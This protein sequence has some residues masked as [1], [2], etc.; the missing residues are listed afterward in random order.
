MQDMLMKSLSWSVGFLA[1][2]IL[3]VMLTACATTR[4]PVGH[5]CA[6]SRIAYP[7]GVGV[8]APEQDAGRNFQQ[9]LARSLREQDAGL[10]TRQDP[11]Q[12]LVL[13]GGGQWGAFGA[14]FLQ[15]WTDSGDRPEFDVV[16][17]VST[18]A[19]IAPY[20]FLGKSYDDALAN[21]YRIESQKDFVSRRGLF[22]LLDANSVYDTGA[23]ARRVLGE[24]KRHRMIELLAREQQT[25][26][27]LLV[28]VVDAD[29]G[30]F[31]AIDLTALAAKDAL[32]LSDREQCMADYMLASGSVP[33]AFSPTF[34]EGRMLMDGS[35]RTNVFVAD[36]STVVA[37]YGIRAVNI[38]VIKNGALKLR[39]DVVRNRIQAIAMRS[40]EVIL[41][42][43]GDTALRDI[44]LQPQLRGQTR[45]VTADSVTCNANDP[46]VV[47][48]LFVPQF[49]SCLLAEGRRIGSQ[50]ESRWTKSLLFPTSTGSPQPEF[51]Q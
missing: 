45:F 14:G 11:W 34:V 25:G 1:L 42:Q 41:D 50:G 51:K 29:N 10:P 5:S 27:R 6:F 17:G 28:G 24:I 38:Y 12:W 31:Y 7:I 26:R 2:L 40:I 19:M 35:A 22:S 30:V 15:G 43:L 3:S 49:M 48:K 36:L 47:A 33:V 20:A 8:D 9:F 13:S 46:E 16:T 4:R 39:P 23:L 32:P 37:R 44:V 21:I 18:G